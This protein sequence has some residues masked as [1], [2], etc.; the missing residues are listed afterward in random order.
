MPRSS[1]SSTRIR[2]DGSSAQV[3]VLGDHVRS[4]E[5]RSLE[6]LEPHFRTAAS[7]VYTAR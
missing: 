3:K 4:V 7:L 5:R 1:G 6:P 2:K